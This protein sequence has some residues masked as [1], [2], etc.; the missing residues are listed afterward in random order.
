ME[1]K[2]T[3]KRD[4]LQKQKGPI[5]SIEKQKMPTIEEKGAY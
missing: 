5:K 4:Q 3:Y 2:E 1:A